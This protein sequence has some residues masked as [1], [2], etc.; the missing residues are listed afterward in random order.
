MTYKYFILKNR[1]NDSKESYEQYLSIYHSGWS[2]M[3][4]SWKKQF[5]QV[6]FKFRF[7]IQWN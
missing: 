6:N 3:K 1:L 4:E 2:H 7:A 5:V